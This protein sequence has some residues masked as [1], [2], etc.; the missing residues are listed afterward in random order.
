MSQDNSQ[1]NASNPFQINFQ[2]LTQLIRLRQSQ[3]QATANNTNKTHDSENSDS[4]ENEYDDSYYPPQPN[5]L[6]DKNITFPT[7]T[8]IKQDNKCVYTNKDNLS[9]ILQKNGINLSKIISDIYN[10]N[11]PWF[12]CSEIV[13]Y[14]YALVPGSYYFTGKMGSGYYDQNC[15]SCRLSLNN[16]GEINGGFFQ[17]LYN[18]NFNSNNGFK[19]EITHGTFDYVN[20]LIEYTKWYF[21]FNY[22]YKVYI[23]YCLIYIL[24]LC[25][26]VLTEWFVNYIE[27]IYLLHGLK[28]C[29]CLF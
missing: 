2:L 23:T 9:N 25:T 7:E 15:C 19:Y 13:L 11:I 24:Y 1:Q 8:S 6:D 29:T 28:M 12:I 22:K 16:F 4:Y 18:N 3:A 10:I 14:T 21:P 17:E 5:L 26:N 27:N 20:G